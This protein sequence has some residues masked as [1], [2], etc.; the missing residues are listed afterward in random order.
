M[1]LTR[2][3]QLGSRADRVMMYPS[4][5][6]DPSEADGGVTVLIPHADVKYPKPYPTAFTCPTNMLEQGLE[7]APE[8]AP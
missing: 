8:L 6:L 1:L 4:H 2:L 7:I 5:M 3:L